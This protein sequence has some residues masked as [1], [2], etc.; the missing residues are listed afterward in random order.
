MRNFA[1]K[2]IKA[3][4]GKQQF[5][6]LVID[7]IAV[8]EDFEKNLEERYKAEIGSMYYQMQ[9][10]SDMEQLAKGD[11]RIRK[12]LHEDAFELKTKHLRLYGVH[13]KRSGK[14]IVLCGFKNSQDKDERRLSSLISQSIFPDIKLL[15]DEEE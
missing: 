8:L 9:R 6:E 2:K 12:D 3:V 11:F 1:I 7:N 13:L 4:E 14:I 10:V 5:Y 15:E